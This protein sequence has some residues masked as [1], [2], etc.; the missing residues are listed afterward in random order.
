MLQRR[1]DAG[2]GADLKLDLFTDIYASHVV[3][4][5]FPH[6]TLVVCRRED[7][8]AYEKSFTP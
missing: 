3:R 8:P 7:F 6:S 1:H 5:I 2:G 4:E